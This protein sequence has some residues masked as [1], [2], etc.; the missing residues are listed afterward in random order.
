MAGWRVAERAVRAKGAGPGEDRVVVLEDDGGVRCAAV[1]DGVT[2]KSGRDYGGASGGALAAD[3]VAQALA[4]LP[5]GV[6]VAEAVAAV[7]AELMELRRKWSV[8]GD[9]LLAPAAVAAVAWPRRRLVWRVGDVHVALGHRDGRWRPHP[10]G[11]LIDTVLAGARAAY[12]HCLLLQ[13]EHPQELAATDPGRALIRPVL[14]RQAV[15]ANREEAGPFGFGLL[16]GRPVPE[17]FVETF[18]LA[19]DVDEVVL[20]SDGYLGPARTLAAAEAELRASL[21]ADRLRIREHPATK[22]MAA[23]ADS[24]DDRSY[25]RVFLGFPRDRDSSSRIS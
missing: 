23:G 19:E 8:A 10:G 9:D 25:V 14:E 13:G 15:L 11:K 12:L 4:T 3:R 17:R 22:A 21:R 5:D 20:A 6:T 2:D 18:E 16:D 24:F 7:S 1:I